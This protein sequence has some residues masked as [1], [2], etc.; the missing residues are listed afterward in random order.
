MGKTFGNVKKYNFLLKELI[1]RDFKVKYKRSFLGVAWSM[2][3]PLLMMSVMAIV[4]S[5]MFKFK[6]DGVNF[7]AYLMSGLIIFNFFSEATNNTLTAVVGN[8]ALINKVY[9]PKYI[10]PLAKVLFAGINFLFT[11]IP[12]FLIVFLSGN[13]VEGTKC[14]I[15]IYYLLMPYIFACT[16]LFTIGIGYI[17]ST[18]TV[19]VRDVIYIWGVCLTILNYVTP[20]F[21]S[22]EMLPERVHF[23]FKFNPLYVYINGIREIVLFGNPL[24]LTYLGTMLLYALLSF[25][26]GLF[27]FK[28][29]QDNFVYYI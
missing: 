9:I 12:F 26:I 19:F 17:L 29:K 4:F 14:Y 13:E 23:L 3:Y 8:G 7:L 2:L 24:T 20:I 28:R 5:N 6:M 22:I 16:L 27:V 1:K 21:Y 25:C 15:N 11:L 10:F 18:V